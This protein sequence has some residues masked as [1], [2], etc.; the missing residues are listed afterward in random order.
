MVLARFGLSA[1]LAATVVTAVRE[2][3]RPVLRFN[4]PVNEVA[5]TDWQAVLGPS[6][7]S[8]PAGQ[9]ELVWREDLAAALIEARESGRPLFVTLRCLPCKQCSDFDKSVLEAGGTLALYLR[10]FI[11]VRITDAAQLDLARLPAV[12][13]QDFDLSWWGY[14]LSS[15]AELYGIFGGRDEVSDTTRMSEAA[16][17]TNLARV[18]NHHYDPRRRSWKVDGAPVAP[19]V[20]T[21]SPRSLPG[22]DSWLASD[23]WAQ[24]QTCLHCHQI[25]NVLRQPELEAGR[26]DKASDVDIWPLPE[27]VGLTLDRDHGLQVMAVEKGSAAEEAGLQIGDQL[28]AAGGQRLF[29][30]ADFRG[31]LHR[32]ANPS[33]SIELHWMREGKHH[34]GRLTLKQGWRATVLDWRMSI[35]QGVIGADPGFFPLKGNR[36]DGRKDAMAVKPYW[37]KNTKQSPAYRAGLRPNHVILAVDGESPRKDGRGF[38]VWFRLRYEFGDTVRFTVADRGKTRDIAVKLAPRDPISQ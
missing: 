9:V 8:W 22:H 17:A 12:G 4:Q 16:L 6:R 10:Q 24:T 34:A 13:Y 25:A 26:F 21:I 38:L 18:L 33:G 23:P 37:G 29:G 3:I 30:Q 11:T 7:G 31:V 36:P 5:A 32:Q 2:P 19:G 15:Q 1:L 14:F 28:G 35:S 20:A 27:N